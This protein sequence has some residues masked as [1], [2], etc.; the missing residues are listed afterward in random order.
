MT[1]SYIFQT[2]PGILSTSEAPDLLK[3]VS[4]AVDSGASFLLIDL[5]Q[6]KQVDSSGIGTLMI[7]CNRLRRGGGTLALCS[8]NPQ[9]RRQIERAGL[10]DKF[11]IYI[12]RHEFDS[13]IAGDDDLHRYMM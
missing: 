8:L 3:W 12:D 7:A 11:D 4:Q 9:V 6:T 10:I 2:T 13:F 1:S 5:S